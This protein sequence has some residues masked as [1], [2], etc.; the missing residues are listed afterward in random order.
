[1]V[2]TNISKANVLYHLRVDVRLF[3]DLLQQ[4]VNDEVKRS[5]LHAAFKAFSQGG[6]YGECDD[7]IVGVLLS[8]ICM[9]QSADASG[10]VVGEMAYIADSPLLL[11][12]R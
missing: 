12:E 9:Y 11:G 7:Y 5:I 8:S 6:A 1:M 2:S 10:L 4:L 3:D